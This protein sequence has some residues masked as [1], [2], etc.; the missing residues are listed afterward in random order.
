MK[1]YFIL[2]LFTFFFSGSYSQAKIDGFYRGS[3]NG[4]TVLG[5]G[6]EDTPNYFI[7]TERSDIGRSL[8]YASFFGAY[9]ITNRLDVNISMP[10]FLNDDALQIQDVSFYL[11]Y[12]A[13]E[14]Q[15]EKSKL[16]LS[17]ALGFSTP[18][19]DYEIGRV[20]DI[21]QQATLLEPRFMLHYK[22][23]SGWFLTFQSGYAFKFEEVPDSLPVTFKVGTALS[24]W[25]F[26]AWYDYQHSFGG[27]DYRGTPR[28]QN[29]R[30]IG[31]DYHKAG[32]T[33]YRSLGV[34]FGV[35][36]SFSYVISGRNVFQGP[37]Y[38]IGLVYDF[39]VR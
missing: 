4:T 15:L 8:F 16:E 1:Q 3:G 33:V 5:L 31:V 9:G 37:A 38:G 18:A 22:G 23:N 36:A 29:F 14:Y 39:K 30:E 11:K 12:L 17:F 35:Y 27:I 20:N 10:F 26:D 2:L 6:Y 13:Y 24:N 34:D 28:P 19:S 25:Y 21:G 7:G 32:G